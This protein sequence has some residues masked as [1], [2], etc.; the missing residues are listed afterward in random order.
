MPLSSL[1]HRRRQPD[2][3]EDLL[4]T[5]F[6]DIIIPVLKDYNEGAEK[7]ITDAKAEYQRR[8]ERYAR[9]DEARARGVEVKSNGEERRRYKTRKNLT[10]GRTGVLGQLVKGALVRCGELGEQR[11]EGRVD[12]GRGRA[13]G[14]GDGAWKEGT[15]HGAGRRHR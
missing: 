15:G 6:H 7:R 13:G 8:E 10:G 2:E 1:F 3:L 12:G 14:R 4:N 9:E 11:G 5:V